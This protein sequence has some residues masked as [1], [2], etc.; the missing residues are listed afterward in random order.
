[1]VMFAWSNG[2]IWPVSIPHRPALD[3]IS[4]ALFYL[5]LC[6]I[7]IRYIRRRNWLDLFII[8]T[9]PLLML[10]SILSLAFPSENPTLNRTAGALIPVFLVI[11]L[12]LD[13]F[14][15]GIESKLTAPIGRVLVWVAGILLLAWSGFQ[16]YDLVFNQYQANYAQ[17]SWNTSEIGRVINDYTDSIGS[18]ENAR[19]VAFPHWVD[20]RLVG[21]NAGYPTRDFAIWP[22]QISE[23]MEDQGPKLFI[24]KFDDVESKALLQNLY[25]QGILQHHISDLPNKDFYQFFVLPE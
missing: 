11:G 10:P 12:T 5:G 20:T 13:G 19:V 4:A 3:V 17:S 7:F 24:V 2:D 1:M 14:L 25:P 18:E 21:I 15:T 22:D 16:N 9:I 23:T 6:L 8:L